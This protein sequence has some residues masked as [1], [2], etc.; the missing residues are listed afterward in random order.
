[1]KKA[2]RTTSSRRANCGL[3]ITAHR[4]LGLPTLWRTRLEP[5]WAEQLVAEALGRADVANEA[6]LV[7]PYEAAEL[8][9]ERQGNLREV[10]FALYRRYEARWAQQE[11]RTSIEH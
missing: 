11:M 5:A 3:V 7:A 2:C 9:P 8:L 6:D 10:Y 1:V 4:D